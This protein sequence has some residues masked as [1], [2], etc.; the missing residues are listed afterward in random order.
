M[1][2]SLEN[3]FIENYNVLDIS[4]II[5]DPKTDIHCRPVVRGHQL[6]VGAALRADESQLNR[7]RIA[8][9]A[10]WHPDL[11]LCGHDLDIRPHP[12]LLVHDFQGT[13]PQQG[14][15]VL[16]RD[17]QQPGR[18]EEQDQEVERRQHDRDSACFHGWPLDSGRMLPARH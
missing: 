6:H 18:S 15:D 17:P 12:S 10:V 14:W 16:G 9:R 4:F 5:L 2:K 8:G 1:I 3:L 13:R 7:L 11:R